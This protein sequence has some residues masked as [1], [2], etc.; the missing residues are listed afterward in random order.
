MLL[1][2][3]QPFPSTRGGVVEDRGGL[4]KHT[5]HSPAQNATARPNRSLNKLRMTI[6]KE[7]PS[8]GGVVEDRGGK[9]PGPAE[10]RV[11][12]K[13]CGQKHRSALSFAS[14]W[15]SKRKNKK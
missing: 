5:M 6:K 1:S 8:H 3:P 15:S 13:A 11:G 12:V 14:F 9:K 7:F 4:N 10:R 2:K